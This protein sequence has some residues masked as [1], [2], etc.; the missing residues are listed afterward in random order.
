VDGLGLL[1]A[2]LASLAPSLSKSTRERLVRAYGTDALAMAKD[3][4]AD[5]GRDLGHG[6][7]EREVA[8]LVRNEWARSVEDVLWRRSKLGL[9]F[10][11][12]E[13]GPLEECLRALVARERSP[14]LA[15]E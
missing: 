11:P 5:W 9:R 7:S 4:G 13:T 1:E 8:W 10:A 2:E 6:L 3:G 14:G 12:D 15:A